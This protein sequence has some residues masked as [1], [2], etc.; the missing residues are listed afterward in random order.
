[1]RVV[2]IG[3]GIGGLAAAVALQRVGI[4]TVIIEQASEIGEV[5]AGL[6]LW[7]NAMNALR[8]LGI[9]KKVLA[10]GAIVE[11]ILSQ[12]L[13]GRQ[14]GITDLSEISRSAEAVCLCIRRAALQRILL[15]E[16]PSSAVRVG[17]RCMG[18]EGSTALLEGGGRIEGDIVVGADG[19]FSV[20]RD[21]LHGTA[22][23]RYAGYTC[24]RPRPQ[25][26]LVSRAWWM[27]PSPPLIWSRLN[28]AT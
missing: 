28:P 27:R 9:A 20:I 5:G 16:L 23:P 21:Q 4:E 19:I 18:F 8:E 15:E 12:S 10:A 14:I 22:E 25:P 7:S 11:R 13:N 17:V 3:A 24:W 2:I 1:M 26:A 6:S